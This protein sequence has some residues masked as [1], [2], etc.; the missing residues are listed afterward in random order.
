MASFDRGEAVRRLIDFALGDD[1]P[2]R[3]FWTAEPSRAFVSH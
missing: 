1:E 3:L 2:A